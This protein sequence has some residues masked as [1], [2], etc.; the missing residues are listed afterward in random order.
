[1]LRL[2]AGENILAVVTTDDLTF[3]DVPADTVDTVATLS[4]AGEAEGVDCLLRVLE[5]ITSTSVFVSSTRNVASVLHENQKT[6]QLFDLAMEDDTEDEDE[7]SGAEES[8]DD[9]AD[10]SAREDED[11]G[12]DSEDE[13]YNA[14]DAVAGDES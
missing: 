11:P 8:G 4:L 6:V 14:D 2:D 3:H 5:D 10:V 1:M 13:H 12:G 7:E 9:N